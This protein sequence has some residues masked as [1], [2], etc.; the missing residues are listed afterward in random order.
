MGIPEKFHAG[1]SLAWDRSI[2]DYPASD[3]WTLTYT[4][5][6]SV[7]KYAFNASANG[8]NYT[9]AVS[10]TTTAPFVAGVYSWVETVAKAGQR[11][12]L[13]SGNVEIL[14]DLMV[15]ANADLRLHAQKM[16]DALEAAWLA[17]AT[18]KGTLKSYQLADVKTEFKDAAD[19]QAQLTYWKKQLKI[20]R[21]QAGI[22]KPNNRIYM[23]L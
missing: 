17:F 3:G 8:E 1:D 15:A 23:R 22:E 14:P 10:T 12:T 13:S 18:S 21:I 9:V 19:L 5:I 7:N 2:A 20:Q 6:N 16:V 11:V 4:L